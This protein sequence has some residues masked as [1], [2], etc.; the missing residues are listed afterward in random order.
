[1]RGD[2]DDAALAAD[3]PD[4]AVFTLGGLR[5]GL[6]HGHAAVPWGDPAAGAALAR[7]LG[8]DVMVAGHSHVLRAAVS[9]EG[10]LHIEPGSATGAAPA[11]AVGGGS[12]GGGGGGG[13]GGSGGGGSGGGAAAAAAA[14]GAPPRPGE[15]ST[16]SFVLMDVADGRAT[17]YTYRLTT[18]ADGG[19]KAVKVEKLSFVKGLPPAAPAAAPGAAAAAGAAAAPP[20]AATAPSPAAA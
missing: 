1:M 14:P 3:W 16:P 4:T 6:T 13:N 9:P 12:G 8:A 2:F 10:V 20:E 11:F 19:P 15:P 17:V 5:F 18:P 7:R